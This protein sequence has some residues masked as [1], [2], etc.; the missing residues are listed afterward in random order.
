MFFLRSCGVSGHICECVCVN[1][2]AAG[3]AVNSQ[4]TPSVPAGPGLWPLCS[5][6]GV[7]CVYEG[8]SFLTILYIHGMCV[9]V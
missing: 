4:E 7:F 1:Q 6:L 9:S 5:C 8:M 2:G 3:H